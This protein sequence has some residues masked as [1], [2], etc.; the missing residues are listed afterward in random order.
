MRVDLQPQLHGDEPMLQAIAFYTDTEHKVESVTKGIRIVFQYDIEVIRTEQKKEDRGVDEDGTTKEDG[1]V[2]DGDVWLE[3]IKAIYS[4]RQGTIEAVANNT[5]TEEVVA[6]I[7]TLHT[8]S[9]EEVGLALE[10]LYRKASIRAEFLKGSD[11]LL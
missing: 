1:E 8:C 7:K 5:A 6:I 3:E 9:I 2:D 11:I 4:Y 10:H